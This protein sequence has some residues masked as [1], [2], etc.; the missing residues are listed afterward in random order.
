MDI[1]FAA[2]RLIHIVA[3]V[4]WVGFGLTTFLYIGPAAASAGE[5]GL[6]FL[7]SFLTGTSYAMMFPIA[8]GVTMLAGILMYLLNA[9]SHFTTTGNIVLGIGA[10][11]GILAGIHGGAV[12]GRATRALG[13]ALNQHIPPDNQPITTDGLSVL[14]ERAQELAS[15]SRISVILAVV[16]L[17]GMASAR[18]L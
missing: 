11:A 3:A 2:L 18:Y 1:L 17:I 13:E 12:T 4:A 7:K 14:R 5:S 16:A 8:A 9:P 6:R 10:I 15:H